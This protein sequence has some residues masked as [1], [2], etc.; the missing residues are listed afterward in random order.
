[1]KKFICVLLVFMIMVIP[2]YA[3]NRDNLYVKVS[4]I[5]LSSQLKKYYNA[6]EYKI[7]NISKTKWEIQDINIVNGTNGDIAYKFA[8]KNEPS[9]LARTW[10]VAGPV[11]LFT[12]GIGWILGV[13]AT[14]VVLIVSN[15][16]KKKV[17]TE[18][19]AYTNSLELGVLNYNET[20]T[21]RTLTSLG[22]VPQLKLIIKNLKTNEIFSVIY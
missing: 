5:E 8:V 19:V 7:T 21:L 3:F 4:N 22:C 20:V 15:N 1:M 18:S 6:Y 17:R 9:A 10:I 16:N 13:I 11:G 12:L 14:P 2:C